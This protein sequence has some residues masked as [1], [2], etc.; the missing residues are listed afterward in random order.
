[1]KVAAV[2]PAYNEEKTVGQVVKAIRDAGVAE[3]IIVV[4]DGSI[5]DT[6][7]MA[8]QAGATVVNLPENVGKGGAMRAGVDRT[9]ADVILFLDADLTGLSHDHLV[10]LVEPVMSGRCDMTVGIFEEGRFATDM[11]QKIAP[12][13]SGQRAILRKTFDQIPR[14]EETGYGVE[15]AISKFADKHALRVQRVELRNVAQIT[16][17][18]KIGFS[19]GFRARLKMYWEIIRFSR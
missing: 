14:L 6:A 16:K 11:A 10:S 5:D 15:R 3:E 8:T 9:T 4:N 18:E 1:M 2:V 7:S 13:L 12:S 19:K 17:E